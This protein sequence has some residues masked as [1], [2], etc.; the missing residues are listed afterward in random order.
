MPAASGKRA[1]MPP[2]QFRGKPTPQSDLYALGCTL[3]FL[4]TAENPEPLTTCHPQQ[5]KPEAKLT[6]DFDK[7]ISTCTQLDTSTRY[8][9]AGDLRADLERV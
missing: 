9:T 5:R 1:F 3:Y 8:K 2:E 7:I 4:V 6:N